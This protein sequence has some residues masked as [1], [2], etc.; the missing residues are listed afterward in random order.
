MLNIQVFIS[1]TSH[2]IHQ[3]SILSRKPFPRSRLGSDATMTYSQQLWEMILSTTCKRLSTSS[4]SLMQSATFYMQD[5]SRLSKTEFILYFSDFVMINSV[6]GYPEQG[7]DTK[8]KEKR[9]KY[10]SM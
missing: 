8:V 5:T 9:Q 3:T 4:P 6:T 1:F 2:L 10:E 7:E